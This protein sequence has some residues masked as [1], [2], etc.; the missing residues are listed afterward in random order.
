MFYPQISTSSDQS[1]F[2]EVGIDKVERWLE[3]RNVYGDHTFQRF[4]EVLSDSMLL[5]DWLREETRGMNM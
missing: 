1:S 4:F 3:L 5:I 2:A